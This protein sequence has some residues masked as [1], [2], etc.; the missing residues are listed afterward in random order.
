M[1]LRTV[2]IFSN[3]RKT[4]VLLKKRV[5]TRGKKNQTSGTRLEQELI[6]LNLF[7]TDLLSYKLHSVLEAFK[8]HYSP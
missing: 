7:C 4:L 1:S 6:Y 5:G 2:F 8:K 3:S